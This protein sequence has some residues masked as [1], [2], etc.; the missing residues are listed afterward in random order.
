MTYE[1]HVKK[2]LPGLE[3]GSGGTAKTVGIHGGGLC[4][5]INHDKCYAD[6][7]KRWEEQLPEKDKW[8]NIMRER[9]ATHYYTVYMM[10]GNPAD[11]DGSVRQFEDALIVL[12]GFGW[13]LTEPYRIENNPM[14]TGPC[15]SMW[16]ELRKAKTREEQ[17]L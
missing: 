16:C 8:L 2:D 11:P 14:F 17:M 1:I 5:D 3:A 4:I 12:R 6:A 7:R 13:E 15:I 9:A 10:E